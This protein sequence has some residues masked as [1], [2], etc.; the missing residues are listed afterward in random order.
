M[1]RNLR[2]GGVYATFSA[3]NEQF[4]AASRQNVAALRRQR[5]AARDLGRAAYR[6]RGRFMLLRQ[7]IGVAL[8]GAILA[9]VSAG[10]RDIGRS[11]AQLG[12]NLRESASRVGLTVRELQLLGRVFEG[13]GASQE[14]FIK[15]LR[16]FQRNLV[17][18]QLGLESYRREFRLLGIDVDDLRARGV[19]GAEAFLE[20]ADGLARTNDQSIRLSAAQTIA[21][22]SGAALVNVLQEGRAAI[23]AQ[24][25]AFASLGVLS[26]EQADTLKR[27]EQSYTDTGTQIRT[28]IAAITADNADLFDSFNRFARVALPEI[29]GGFV[30]TLE[31][32]RQNMALV[33]AGAIALGL[34]IARSTGVLRLFGAAAVLAANS[35][36]SLA[37]ASAAAAI[38]AGR[39][40]A[41][42]LRAGLLALAVAIGEAVVRFGRLR[43][44]LGS[45][46]EAF[47]LVGAAALEVFSRIPRY[48]VIAANRIA[49]AFFGLDA[50]LG[51]VA[52]AAGERILRVFRGLPTGIRIAMIDVVNTVIAAV[53]R[54]TALVSSSGLAELLNIRIG[55]IDAIPYPELTIE[56]EGRMRTVGERARDAF[57]EHFNR[58]LFAVPAERAAPALDR[59]RRLAA[60]AATE[61]EQSMMSLDTAADGVVANLESAAQ[62]AAQAAAA[63]GGQIVTVAQDLTRRLDQIYAS[64]VDRI[65]G[66]VANS[67]TGLESFGDAAKNV[68]R[69]IIS[70]ILSAYIRSGIFSILGGLGFS[71]PGGLAPGG[72]ARGGLA[73][74]GF[75]L[76]GERGPEIVDFRSPGRVYSNEQLAGALSGGGGMVFNFA[77]VVNSSD[78]G[79]VDRAL[80]DAYPIFE[81]RIRSSLRQDLHRPSAM[82]RR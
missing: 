32:F 63:S 77:P 71:L 10:F 54:I 50:A 27:L 81:E 51:E 6:L 78:A 5:Q 68:A 28:Q 17:Q 31:F 66:V 37:G 70:E 8:G 65:S 76:V 29:F 49:G 52:L 45:A 42:L 74:R 43:A 4:L 40:R 14:T 20:F 61:M 11:S 73:G 7:S 44:A 79:A 13:G 33:R 75:Q 21:G 60:D 12:A 16:T 48:A 41:A 15:G 22:R 19:T 39:L 64:G 72:F 18:A 2:V 56:I 30:R 35:M 24:A 69:S 38:A 55:A 23:E 3:R 67:I 58:D 62:A 46:G 53:N 57:A 59:L 34:A 25:E 1:P 26:S 47:R 82:N 36:R 9:G 80:S